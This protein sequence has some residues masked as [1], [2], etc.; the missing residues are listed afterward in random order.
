M[1]ICVIGGIDPDDARMVDIISEQI[2]AP[3]TKIAMNTPPERS[4][5]RPD[6]TEANNRE[7]VGLKTHLDRLPIIPALAVMLVLVGLALLTLSL[8]SNADRPLYPILPSFT[9]VASTISYEPILISF[10]ELNE[11]PSVFRGQRIQVSGRYTPVSPPE[12]PDH[13]GPPIRWS[14]VADELQL[15]AIGFENLLRLLKDGTEMTVTGIWSAYHGPVGCGKGPPD[16][17]VW[18]LAVDR[19]L[20]PNPLLSGSGPVVTVITGGPLPTLSPFETVEGIT[21]TP[22]TELIVT[23]EITLTAT[24]PSIIPP[25][26]SPTPEGTILP[27]TPL[28][29]PGTPSGITGT[30]PFSGTPDETSTIDPSITPVVTEGPPGTPTPGFPTSTP[31]GPGYPSPGTPTPTQPG[32]YP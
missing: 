1:A 30:P 3:G 13:N 25:S 14:L 18:F 15:N 32:G 6:E 11:D 8:R 5:D 12:C 24:L 27:V 2:Q 19:I 16:G 23:E 28:L 20:E 26:I 7:I 17:T 4:A 10:S 29:T 22:T 21:P 9:P 31:S